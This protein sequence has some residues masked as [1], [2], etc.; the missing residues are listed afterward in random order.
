MGV[1]G[2]A[3]ALVCGITTAATT[4]DRPVFS[5]ESELVVV[6]VAVK[7]TKG[8]PVTGLTKS[9]FTVLED[10][11]AQSIGVFTSEDAPVTVGLVVD[12]S[13]SM[14]PNRDQV[15]LAA[16]AFAEASNPQDELF[17]LAFNDEVRAA[18]PAGAPFTSDV[19]TLRDA[20]A[21]ALGARG[22]TAL[23]DGLSAGLDH[24]RRGRYERKVLVLVSDG[25]DNAS[26]ATLS[27]V[28]TKTLTSNALIYTVALVDPVERDANPKLL[29]RIAETSGGEAFE[30]ADARGIT[31]ALQ[32]IAR[33]IRHVYTVGYVPTNPARDGTLRKLRVV[34][35]RPDR[36]RVVVRT[37]AGYLAGH[38]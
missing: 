12:N 3:L 11:H 35:Q 37:R 20:L 1:I 33:D 29:K 6:H 18:L 2:V 27:D 14:Q 22:R 26:H 17:V 15:V 19:S 13:G 34:V 10:G 21:N 30:P 16:T 28:M 8:Q 23:F 7:D 25:G 32:R 38:M 9:A 36:R 24:L 4:Q 5:V 31:D